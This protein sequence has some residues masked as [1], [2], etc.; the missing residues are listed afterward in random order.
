MSLRHVKTKVCS[1]EINTVSSVELSVIG[2]EVVQEAVRLDDC[3]L[4]DCVY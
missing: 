4:Q 2:R 3:F 1:R